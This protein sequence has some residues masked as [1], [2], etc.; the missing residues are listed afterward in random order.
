MNT[1]WKKYFAITAKDDPQGYVVGTVTGE[2]YT[3]LRHVTA[4]ELRSL[5]P[6]PFAFQEDPLEVVNTLEYELMT[7]D[8]GLPYAF[9]EVEDA[10]RF[11]Q[12]V[13]LETWI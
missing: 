13:A 7:E 9:P 2:T 11:A 12:D 4:E 8:D 3:V 10:V 5:P 1:Q 6:D